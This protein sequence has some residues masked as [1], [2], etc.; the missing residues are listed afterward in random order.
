MSGSRSIQLL[1]RRIS[2]AG[3]ADATVS[4]LRLR[5]WRV[6]GLWFYCSVPMLVGVLLLMI[7]L[8]LS[9]ALPEPG[10]EREPLSNAAEVVGI[11]AAALIVWGVW[12]VIKYFPAAVGL[13]DA[14]LREVNESV[15]TAY[16]KVTWRRAFQSFLLTAISSVIVGALFVVPVVLSALYPGF[17]ESLGFLFGA[18][19]FVLSVVVVLWWAFAQVSLVVEDLRGA[20]ALRRARELLSGQYWRLIV[21]YG[22]TIILANV[23]NGVALAATGVFSAFAEAAEGSE[24]GSIA[25]TTL[26]TLGFGALTAGAFVVATVVAYYQ[27]RIHFEGLDLHLRMNEMEAA[28][29]EQGRQGI[30]HLAVEIVDTARRK[31]STRSPAPSRG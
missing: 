30:D 7:P 14:T 19:A 13:I 23:L 2:V 22:G 17:G 26:S 15:R 24:L 3:L 16:R 31:P 8:G 29:P 6:I 11:V 9:V 21:V 10:A 20:D 28:P 18:L 1:A 27:S 4:V 12:R 25:L 5:F